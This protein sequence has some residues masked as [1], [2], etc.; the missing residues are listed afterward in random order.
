M[1]TDI[2]EQLQYEAIKAGDK[3]WSLAFLLRRAAAEIE[4]LR[5]ASDALAVELNAIQAWEARR[6]R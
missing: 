1:T 3:E 4:V 2:V 6:E 5:A